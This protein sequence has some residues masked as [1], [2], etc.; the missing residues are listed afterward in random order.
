[1]PFPQETSQELSQESLKVSSQELSQAPTLAPEVLYK[2]RQLQQNFHPVSV[3]EILEAANLTH[4]AQPAASKSSSTNTTAYPIS[5]KKSLSTLTLAERRRIPTSP[6]KINVSTPIAVYT[7][8]P[9]SDS[10]TSNK[11][12]FRRLEAENAKLPP[13]DSEQYLLARLERQ[14]ALLNADLKSVC[15]ESNR[16]KADFT[17]LRNLISDNTLSPTGVQDTEA[18]LKQ[19][20]VLSTAE[21]SDVSDWDFWQCVV[22]DFSLVAA[23]LPHLLAAKLRYGGI[24]HRLRG[25]IWQTMTRSSATNL[26]SMY[27]SL[28]KDEQEN[29]S[30]YGRVIQRDLSRTFP[31]I[32]MF[33][34]DQGE[35]QQAMGRLLK[36][37]SVYDAH[38][39]YCQGLAFLVG[40]LLLVMPEKQ[41][42][43]KLPRLHAHL[44]EHTIHPAMYASQWY[45]TLFAYTLP[46][47]LVLRIYDLAFAEG[48]V[49]TIT[50]VAIAV[51]EK[52]EERL[53]AIHD[54]EQ[55]MIYLSSRK[56][57]E[58]AYD[59]NPDTVI[60]HTM[61]LSTLITKSKLDNIA[62][63][64]LKEIEQEKDR[65]HQ[66]LAVRFNGWG[67][68][69]TDRKNKRE[70]WFSWG[71]EAIQAAQTAQTTQA[72]SPMKRHM[73][74]P[75][76]STCSFEE[77]THDRTI[78]LLH[79]QIED[80]V[81]ALSQLQKEHS[82]I[83]EELMSVKMRETDQLN[84]QEKVIERNA[85]LE[86]R[87]KKYK[88]KLY[89]DR[90]TEAEP[91][92]LESPTSLEQDGQFRSFV[93]S[94]RLTGDFGALIAGALSDRIDACEVK[95]RSPTEEE[96]HMM[97]NVTAELVSYKLANF[98][99]GQKYEQLCNSHEQLK[100]KLQFTLDDQ[101]S[102]MDKLVHLQNESEAYQVD[103]DELLSEREELIKENEELA[104]KA[105]IAKKTSTELQLEKLF[106]QKEVEAQEKR[107][108][109][110]EDEK[111]EYL[112]PRDSFTEEVF[113]A[114]RTL[115][116]PKEEKAV[117][118]P[119]RRHT[120]QMGENSDLYH[121]EYQSKYIESELRC[122]ELE[123]LLAEAKF[124][125]VQHETSSGTISPRTSF[126]QR[127]SSVQTKRH[128]ATSLSML[129]YRGSTPSSP[130]E[131]RHERTNSTFSVDPRLSMDS[132]ISANSSASQC[133]TSNK[134][135][136][137]VYARLWTAFG[138]P[139]AD[140]TPASSVGMKSPVEPTNP[141]YEEPAII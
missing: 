5:V 63:S 13:Q 58:E 67:K 101:S 17:T 44:Q 132:M 54:F 1:M 76:I 119:S 39:G 73:S 122:R 112:M 60:A 55:L 22:D 40:P 33:K 68:S 82:S 3:D 111:R 93:D 43:C 61:A 28:V 19:S 126:Q 75:T 120:L 95:S 103:K 135:R 71:N 70:S 80:L 52:N 10:S 53:L 89:T 7:R 35:G 113:A 45:L 99:M 90:A 114:H 29:P 124:K 20:P 6:E 41:A 86:Q 108:R 65:A 74:S 117:V 137:S 83:S 37:Y 133:S 26:E 51:M 94:L 110:L 109:E 36:A 118:H 77:T 25:V 96:D 69:K 23:K 12:R 123:K 139:T 11:D 91:A 121:R 84:E 16:L 129:A 100:Q 87:I 88:A 47:S 15:I 66:V 59:S 48:A 136:S 116:H 115:F 27:D 49:E 14:N 32:E 50:R 8:S 24:P 30:P 18:L 134:K 79:Q 57:Y 72:T 104:E 42:F 107:V 85:V 92:S 64:H 130:G 128:S 125:L 62:E 38:V 138:S 141:L 98:E 78:P 46:L 21:S 34:A 4:L 2:L 97:R 140:S 105:A 56:L 127:R 131:S 81:V 9:S 106:L 102:L 31:Q